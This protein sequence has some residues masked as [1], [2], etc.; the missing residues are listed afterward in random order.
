MARSALKLRCR[1]SV[2]VV[3]FNTGCGKLCEHLVSN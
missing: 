2:G 3:L 1:C